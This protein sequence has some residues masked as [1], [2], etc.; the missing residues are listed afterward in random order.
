MKKK[1]FAPAAK[2]AGN[3]FTVVEILIVIAIIAALLNFMMFSV[4]GFQAEARLSQVRADLRALQVAIEAY[5]KN[6]FVY[7][8]AENYQTTLLREVPRVLEENLWDPFATGSNRA[9]AL[10]VSSDRSYYVI[11][12]VGVKGEGGVFLDDAGRVSAEG[13]AIYVTNGRGQQ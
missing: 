10:A 7:P 2:K 8:Q 13:N 9:Y 11:Y 1:I 6:H 5:N 4:Q 3:G 12:S